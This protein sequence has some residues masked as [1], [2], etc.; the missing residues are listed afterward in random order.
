M[1]KEVKNSGTSDIYWGDDSEEVDQ[2]EEIEESMINEN[3]QEKLDGDEGEQGKDSVEDKNSEH[4]D[5]AMESGEANEHQLRCCL[6]Q[7]H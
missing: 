5:A 3:G 2:N 6:E 4:A 7:A 1:D